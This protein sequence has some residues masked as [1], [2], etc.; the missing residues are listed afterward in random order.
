MPQRAHILV[1]EAGWEKSLQLE[2]ADLN[3]DF[4][5]GFRVVSSQ[6]IEHVENV[7]QR[8]L[9]GDYKLFLKA[10]GCGDFPYKFG[11]GFFSPD[12]IIEGCAGPILMLAGTNAWAG[13]EDQRRFY[14][15]RGEF[16]PDPVRFTPNITKYLGVSLFDL[17]QIG[18]DG[19]G[20]YYQLIC[21]H[22][23]D[24]QLGFCRITPEGTLEDRYLSFSEGLRAIFSRFRDIGS[25]GAVSS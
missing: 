3:P 6:E 18:Y 9:P 24:A 22:Q 1:G 5:A 11:G 4:W 16:N 23:S 21:P 2:T 7:L 14:I 15:S 12:E 19:M 10:F 8:R 17:V 20:C 13:I 25:E